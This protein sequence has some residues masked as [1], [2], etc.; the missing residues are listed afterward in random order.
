MLPLHEFSFIKATAPYLDFK[1][2]KWQCRGPV[3]RRNITEIRFGKWRTWTGLIT[4]GNISVGSSPAEGSESKGS[5]SKAWGF[6][7]L[8]KL[9]KKAASGRGTGN[10][11]AFLQ[12]KNRAAT[13]RSFA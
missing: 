4:S 1:E 11:M 10:S 2:E 9:A 5:L 12:R 13:S 6:L 3:I 7:I 8:R